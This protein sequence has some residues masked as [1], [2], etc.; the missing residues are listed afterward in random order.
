MKVTPP[1]FSHLVHKLSALADGRLA[2]ILEGG[3]HIESLGESV[4]YS[5]RGLLDDPLPQLNLNDKPRPE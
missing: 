4:A 1:A 3:Y 2:V 5:V